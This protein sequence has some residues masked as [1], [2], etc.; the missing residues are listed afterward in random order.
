[1][2]HN[3]KYLLWP[4]LK[5]RRP[6]KKQILAIDDDLAIRAILVNVLKK[7]F[8][9]TSLSSG[10][11]ALLWLSNG[12]R[13]DLI[14]SDVNM[15]GLDGFAFLKALSQSGLH[16]FIPVIILSGH[17]ED[18]I[19]AQSTVYSNLRCWIKKPFDPLSIKGKI[20][21]ILEKDGVPYP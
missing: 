6:K 4:R 7:D 1:M 13:P 21:S 20:I 16:N 12:N 9:V 10:L 18:E 14:I 2:S 11:E 19:K 17:L 8:N 15:P 5:E 3:P